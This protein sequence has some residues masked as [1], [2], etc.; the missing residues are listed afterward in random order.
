VRQEISV[1]KLI[2]VLVASG[3]AALP[4]LVMSGEAGAAAGTNARVS[5]D[6]GSAYVSADQMGGTGSY[7][8]A[9]LA[10]CGV[11]RRPQNEPTLA[12]D[13]RN[14]LVWVAGSNEYCDVPVDGDGWTGYYRSTTGGASW[15]DSLVPGYASDTSPQAQSSPLHA[16]AARGATAAGDPLL[17]WDAEGRAFYMGNNFSRGTPDGSSFRTR[18]N[19][20]SIWVSTYEPS[21]PTNTLTDGAKFVRTVIVDTNTSGQGQSTDKTGIAVDPANGNIYAAWS[22]FHGSGCND[23]SFVRSTDHGRTFSK[24][25]KLSTSLCSSQGPYLAIGPNGAIYMTWSAATQGGNALKLGA[26]FTAS[27]DQGRTFSKPVF[28]ATFSRFTSTP[29][30]GGAGRDCGDDV[31]ACPSGYVFPRFDSSPTI[32]ADNVNGTIV[33]AFGVRQSDGQ[34][35]IEAVVSHNGGG[36]WSQQPTVVGPSLT[37]HQFFPWA[38]AS[39]GRVSVV[40]YDSRGDGG[41]SP[42][43]PPCTDA[44]KHTSACLNVEYASSDDGGDTWNPAFAVTDALTNPNLEQFSGRAIPFFGDYI[45]VSAVGNTVGA[46]W[47]DQRDAVL[48]S[49]DDGDADGADVAGDPAAGGSCTDIFSTCFDGTGGIDQNIYSASITP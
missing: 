10:R 48:A 1:R 12:I 44:S 47:T 46:V 7:T 21:D 19:I 40:W 18:T 17:A 38:T 32:A 9:A 42:S 31:F 3:A 15:T 8:D 29:F 24:P 16:L 35:L 2:A 36:Q 49:D 25:T 6:Q 37:G 13:P 34:G 45:A 43:R 30:S 28:A 27:T 33:I 39:G 20:G 5:V 22:T 4:A 26:A 14:P 11:D 41:Y 23:I